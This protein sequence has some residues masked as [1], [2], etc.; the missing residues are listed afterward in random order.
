MRTSQKWHTCKNRLLIKNKYLC[1]YTIYTA[2]CSCALRRG[3]EARPAIGHEPCEA[4]S[5]QSSQVARNSQL[6]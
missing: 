1:I 4:M 2:M 3:I 6:P 5:L